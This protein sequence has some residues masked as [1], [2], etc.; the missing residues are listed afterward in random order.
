VIPNDTRKQPPTFPLV[1][2]GHN[3]NTLE[4]RKEGRKER[5][6]GEDD[7]QS[8]IKVIWA[9]DHLNVTLDLCT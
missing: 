1:P 8:N 2:I 5:K 9:G 4:G 7:M 3:P 6:A